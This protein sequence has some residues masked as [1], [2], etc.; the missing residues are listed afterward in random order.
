MLSDFK[1]VLIAVDGEPVAAHAAE[2]G[3]QL[4]C[5]LGAE[6]AFIHAIDPGLT[7]S[8]GI[9]PDQLIAEAERDARRMLAELKSLTPSLPA[10]EFIRVGKPAHEILTAATE[11]P[12]SVIVI[13]SHGRRGIS[14]VLMGSV[15]EAVMRN[16]PCPA[17][18]VRAK[19]D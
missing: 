9:A 19:I 8:P 11:W 15:A 12:A 6:V 4:A 14:R 16:A 18:V 3:V 1:R 5:S 7:Y 13:G 17:L 2:I 10:L